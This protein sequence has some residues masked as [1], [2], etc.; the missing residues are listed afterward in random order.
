MITM[1]DILNITCEVVKVD[2]NDVLLPKSKMG[3]RKMDLVSAR[4]IGMAI[5]RELK[6][7]TFYDIGRFYQR[8][9][10]DVIY[11][12]RVLQNELDTN[13]QKRELKSI[14]DERVLAFKEVYIPDYM[15]DLL[16]GE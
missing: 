1:S 13:R 8:S 3:S 7:G 16:Q 12:I 10:C 9:H 6:L 4:Y 5:S 11:G 14:I 15:D 2:P